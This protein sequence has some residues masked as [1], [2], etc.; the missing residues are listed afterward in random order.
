[1]P[2]TLITEMVKRDAPRSEADRDN[3]AVKNPERRRLWT[4]LPFDGNRRLL[5]VVANPSL[6]DDTGRQVAGHIHRCAAHIKQA[7]D[8]KK[9][10]HALCRDADRGQDACENDD[11]DAGGA[12][13]SDGCAHH[14]QNDQHERGRIKRYAVNLCH[15]E[16]G[17][18]LVERRA[19]MLTVAPKGMMNRDSAGDTDSFSVATRIETGMVAAELEVAKASIGASRMARANPIGFLR[20][21]TATMHR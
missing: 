16:R 9:D 1:M 7:V 17:N 11:A 6:H 13:A 18:H 21:R 19:T 4:G 3:L 8:A 5:Y 10:R 14:R 20:P 2:Q 12:G 15:E